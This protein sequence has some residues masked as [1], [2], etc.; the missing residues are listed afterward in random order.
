MKEKR[1]NL[2]MS[3]DFFTKLQ[4]AAAKE[5]VSISH[6]LRQAAREKIEKQ[7]V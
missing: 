7:C 5:D 4:S 1:V 3:N 2:V 6:F